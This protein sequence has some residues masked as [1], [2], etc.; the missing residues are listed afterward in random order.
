MPEI[1]DGVVEIKACAREPGHRTKIA[2]WSNDHNVDPVGACVGARGARVR[3][4][5]NE[6]RGEKIDIVPFSED[7]PDFVMKALSPAKVKEVRI[8]E[9]TGTAEV[10]VPDYQLSLAIGKEGQN[11]RLAARLT[12]WR[13]DIKSE[14]Q[15]AE[16]EAYAGE[17]WAEGEWVV[18]AET[19]EQVWQPAEGGAA[20]SRRGVGSTAT[21]ADEDEA[22]AEADAAAEPDGR[23]RRGRCRRRRPPRPTAEVADG[24]GR[25]CRRLP[26]RQPASRRPTP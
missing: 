6:L 16:E 1:A 7:P 20:V 14:T 23:G 10:I 21:P 18:D 12:G 19:G 15:L 13:V 25:G 22:T 3:M 2:V 26:S 9:D 8:D 5:V 11:A 4:V 24:R 17:E